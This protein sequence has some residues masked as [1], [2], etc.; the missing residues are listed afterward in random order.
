[1]RIL[2]RLFTL[3]AFLIAAASVQARTLIHAGTLIDGVR[4]EPQKN[5]T[6]VIDGE[7]IVEVTLGLQTA[8]TGDTVIDLKAATVMPGFMDMHTHLSGEFSPQ[9]YSE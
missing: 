2:P 9:S 4:A 7:R 5:V 8:G 6:I 1:M 3:V